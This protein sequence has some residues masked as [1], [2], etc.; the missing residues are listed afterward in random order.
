MRLAC[1]LVSVSVIVLT[2]CN[3]VPKSGGQGKAQTAPSADDLRSRAETLWKARHA[4]D[5]KAVYL[6]ETP[7]RRQK[8]EPEAGIKWYT[9]EYPFEVVEYEIGRVQAT[10]KVGWVEVDSQMAMRKFPDLP[11][12]SAKQWEIWQVIDGEWYPVPPEMRESFP[13]PPIVRDAEAEQSLLQRHD[14]LWRLRQADEWAAIYEFLA[15]DNREEV[16]KERFVSFQEMLHKDRPRELLKYEIA[17]IEVI[18]KRGRICVQYQTKIVD[19][20]MTKAPPKWEPTIEQWSLHDG[21]WYLELET[22]WQ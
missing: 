16:E 2:G 21:E 18:D 12:R 13:A 10:D 9:E 20:N 11:P 14:A 7:E 22:M 5:W 1:F 4:Q 17:W 3:A 19:P 8:V 6:F 15:P